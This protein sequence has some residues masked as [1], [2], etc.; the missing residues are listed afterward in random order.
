MMPPQVGGV[1][2]GVGVGG[3]RGLGWTC[4]V[5]MRCVDGFVLVPARV[6][7]PLRSNRIESNRR[8]IW[9]GSLLMQIIHK[10]TTP[11]AGRLSRAGVC[12]W[13]RQHWCVACV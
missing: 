11:T 7:G 13:E 6:V 5:G 3:E 1:G 8:A 4:G 9:I 2:V 12:C 10:Q